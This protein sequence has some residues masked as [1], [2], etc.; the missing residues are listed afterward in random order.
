MPVCVTE[1]CLQSADVHDWFLLVIFIIV[2]QYSFILYLATIRSS[3]YS[4]QHYDPEYVCVCVVVINCEETHWAVCQI[5]TSQSYD[6]PQNKFN[7]SGSVTQPLKQNKL[8]Y[9]KKKNTHMRCRRDTNK[10][11]KTTGRSFCSIGDTT[12]LNYICFCLRCK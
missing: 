8:T 2:T 3:A 12:K 10:Y 5:A 7:P 4:Y 6:S 9:T 11:L 1:N